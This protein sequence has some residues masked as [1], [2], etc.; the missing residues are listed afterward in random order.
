MIDSLVYILLVR[1]VYGSYRSTFTAVAYVRVLQVFGC[2][3]F[4]VHVT[5]DRAKIRTSWYLSLAT[6][7]LQQEK[8]FARYKNCPSFHSTVD[9]YLSWW[10]ILCLCISFWW[11]LSHGET[12]DWDEEDSRGS[13]LLRNRDKHI[14]SKNL[15]SPFISTF[16]SC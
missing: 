8:T 11:R 1:L 12:C 10:P 2:V 6:K 5:T 14:N 15:L 4:V 13:L 16:S 3:V 9:S 7:D